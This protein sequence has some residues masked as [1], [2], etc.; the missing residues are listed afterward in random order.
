MSRAGPSLALSAT[1]RTA[2]T[3]NATESDSNGRFQDPRIFRTHERRANAKKAALE[4]FKSKPAVDPQFEER[5]AAKRAA[6][7]AREAR[8]AQRKAERIAQAE[9]EQAAR[10]AAIAAEEAAR[11]AAIEEEKAREEALKAAQK[12]ARDAR[13]AARKARK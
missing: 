1:R 4:K 12:A 8:A 9:A 10:E 5:Q 13:Y 11:L 3:S 6:R 2:F 7:E